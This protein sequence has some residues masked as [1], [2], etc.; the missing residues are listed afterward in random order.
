MARSAYAAVMSGLLCLSPAGR[1]GI[2]A[3]RVPE[4]ARSSDGDDPVA[5]AFVESSA[6]GLIELARL[7]DGDSPGPDREFWRGFARRV[8]ESII[9]T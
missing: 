1:L 7:P 4:A 3:E 5:A 9:W 8:A 2:E 6:R